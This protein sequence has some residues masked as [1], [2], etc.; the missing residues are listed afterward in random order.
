MDDRI[1]YELVRSK[2]LSADTFESEASLRTLMTSIAEN[3]DAA[4]DSTIFE[5]PVIHYDEDRERWYA[6]WET[7]ILGSLSLTDISAELMQLRDYQD[8]VDRKSTRL[9][10]SHV[11][12]SY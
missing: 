12:S 5:P 9:N 1:I 7:R 2:A 4:H 11:A 10:S 3:L 6:H 8:L